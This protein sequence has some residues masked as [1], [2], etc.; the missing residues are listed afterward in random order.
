M[1]TSRTV[2]SKCPPRIRLAAISSSHALAMQAPMRGAT[3]RIVMPTVIS[4]T[5]MIAMNVEAENG[6]RCTAVG[7]R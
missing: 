1:T 3:A 2:T 7:L 4:T 5:P 6:S